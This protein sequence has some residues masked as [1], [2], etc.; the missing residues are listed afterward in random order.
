MGDFS[1][2]VMLDGK[3][4]L[5]LNVGGAINA[6]CENVGRAL[7]DLAGMLTALAA[8]D[9]TRRITADYQGDFATLKQ[10]AN[11][12]AGAIGSMIGQIR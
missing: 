5:I 4:G 3:T 12:T 6:L 9:L 7:E 1:K 8:G 2:R 10:S 11:E